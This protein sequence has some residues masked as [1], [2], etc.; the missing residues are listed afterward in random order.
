MN[1]AEKQRLGRLLM[2]LLGA[3]VLVVFLYSDILTASP[4]TDTSAADINLAKLSAELRELDQMPALQITRED[5]GDAFELRRTVFSFDESPE[6]RAAEAMR[7]RQAREA[8]EREAQRVEEI[9]RREAEAPPQPPPPPPPPEPPQFP[10]T[11]Y[12][13]AISSTDGETITA[14]LQRTGGGKDRFV[15]VRPGDII[16]NKFVIKQIDRD[17]LT[18]GYTDERFKDRS[19]TLQLVKPSGR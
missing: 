3:F 14:C 18:I 13:H 10:F 1:A 19:T 9:R 4:Q 12:G 16:E 6:E 8:A 11:Y 5:A 2:V 17:S 7:A 15:W